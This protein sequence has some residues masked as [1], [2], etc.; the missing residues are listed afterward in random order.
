MCPSR[1]AMSGLVLANAV[2]LVGVIS[3]G[4]DIHSLLVVYWVESGVVGIQSVLKIL[5]A[6]GTDDSEALP[7]MSFNDRSVGSFIGAP[8]R[9]IAR[10]FVSHYG[11]FWLVHGLFVFVLPQSFPGVRFA[12]V[13]VVGLAAVGLAIYHAISYRTNFI[14]RE[15]YARTGPVTLMVEPY[16]RVFVLH[17]TIV[18]GGFGVAALGAPVGA[19]A[20]MV[21]AKT[22]LDLRG[23]WTEHDRAQRRSPSP[24]PER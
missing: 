21:L 12:R 18:L 9:R 6:T 1:L 4:W 22:A 3:F 10:F 17:V 14:G 24:A 5:R 2:P 15:E 20:V 19:L 11:G 8:N 16:R 7:S 13:D 23:H